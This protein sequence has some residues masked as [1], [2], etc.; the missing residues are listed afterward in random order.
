MR[1]VSK[2][3]R[4]LG[5]WGFAGTHEQPQPKAQQSYIVYV[6]GEKKNKK[7]GMEDRS[8]GNVNRGEW[9]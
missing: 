7:R 5:F 1:Q 8:R 6:L 3:S 9:G 2:Q 4:T